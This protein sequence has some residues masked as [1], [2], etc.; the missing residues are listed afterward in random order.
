ME[1]NQQYFQLII[2]NEGKDLVVRR[3]MS[4]VNG[5]NVEQAFY[6]VSMVSNATELPQ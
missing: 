4:G 6:H 2:I 3:N 5:L 1:E